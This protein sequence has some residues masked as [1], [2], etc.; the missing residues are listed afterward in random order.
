[1]TSY[2]IPYVT[3]QRAGGERS[4]DIWSRLL[5]DRIVYLGTPIDDGVANV[6]VAQMLHL[7]SENPDGEISLYVNSPGGS[8]TAMLS[9]YDTMRYITAPVAT[10]CV[11]EAG[12]PV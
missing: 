3:Q 9:V 5:A 6:L 11:G 4:L 8:P 12:R 10:T 2:T 1:M 7:N